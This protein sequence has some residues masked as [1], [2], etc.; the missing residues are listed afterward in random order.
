MDPG[1]DNDT[2]ALLASRGFTVGRCIHEKCPWGSGVYTYGPGWVIKAERVMGSAHRDRIQLEHALMRAAGSVHVGPVVQD[3]YCDDH[4]AYATM[5]RFHASLAAVPVPDTTTGLLV[6]S[7]LRG[8]AYRMRTLVAD[9]KPDNVVVMLSAGG[10]RIDQAA[11]ID[12]E[13]GYCRRLPPHI[14]SRWAYLAMLML[15][16]AVAAKIGP[17]AHA[18]AIRPFIVRHAPSDI[19]AAVKW[20]ESHPLVQRTLRQYQV[21]APRLWQVAGSTPVRDHTS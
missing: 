2:R 20:A 6:A 18:V 3:T 14:P 1:G 17:P 5:R 12:F 7:L 15:F 16:H 13:P 9:L 19:R 4:V 21:P 8:A 11:L 10:S